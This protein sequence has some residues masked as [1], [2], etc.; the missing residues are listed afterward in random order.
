MVYIIHFQLIH[1]DTLH[2]GHS[3]SNEMMAHALRPRILFN[4][5]YCVAQLSKWT[6][7]KFELPTSNNF[8]VRIICVTHGRAR[9][10]AKI[11][12]GIIFPNFEVQ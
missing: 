4:F 12:Y 3:T 10:W 6:N 2:L 9:F 1:L 11:V 7:P 5:F 8:S